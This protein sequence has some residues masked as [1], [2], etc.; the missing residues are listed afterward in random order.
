MRVPVCAADAG[1]CAAIYWC[2]AELDSAACGSCFRASAVQRQYETALAAKYS[3]CFHR[4]FCPMGRVAAFYFGFLGQ[5]DCLGLL[6]GL[7][8]SDLGMCLGLWCM[9]CH[10]AATHFRSRK[11]LNMPSI[12]NAANAFRVC[13]IS[14]CQKYR[15]I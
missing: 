11:P 14:A 12:G 10:K 15:S 3:P 6:C 9:P 8:H 13:G 2:C 4:G 5:C 7:L 1:V